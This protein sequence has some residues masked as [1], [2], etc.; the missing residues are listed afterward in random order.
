M[1]ALGGRFTDPSQKKRRVLNLD[2]EFGHIA[3]V[4]QPSDA[5]WLKALAQPHK[6]VQQGLSSLCLPS[7]IN[8][9]VSEHFFNEKNK[10]LNRKIEWI[11]G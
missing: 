2:L 1:C 4:Q 3:Y 11:D 7:G 8:Q 6:S 9:F 5:I 10:D